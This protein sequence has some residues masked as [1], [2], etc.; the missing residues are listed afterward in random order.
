M[1]KPAD[2][3]ELIRDSEYF[4]TELIRRLERLA[5]IDGRGSRNWRTAALLLRRVRAVARHRLVELRHER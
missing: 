3:L 4:A 2:R 5:K 1:N